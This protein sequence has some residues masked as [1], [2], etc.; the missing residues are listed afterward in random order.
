MIGSRVLGKRKN[1][2]LMRH[3]GV[4]FFAFI[5]TRL[6]GT[7][8]TDI[9][10]GYRTMRAQVPTSGSCRNLRGRGWRRYRHP[11][12]GVVF[13]CGGAQR[14]GEAR[15]GTGKGFAEPGELDAALFLRAAAYR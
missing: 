9:S 7:K 6:T 14:V 10:S 2:D 12:Q 13:E 3:A 1:R 8:V 5:V 4:R 15:R 11:S